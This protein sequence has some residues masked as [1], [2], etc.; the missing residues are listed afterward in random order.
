MGLRY[1]VSLAV[2]LFCVDVILAQTAAPGQSCEKN[3]GTSCEQC[4][5]NVSCLWCIK[6]QSC[7]TYP[8]KTILPPHAL[9]PLNDA[10][11]GLCSMNFQILI[12]TLSVVAAVIIIAFFVCLFCC[13][14]CEN[15]GSAAFEHHMQKK[16]E[17]RKIKQDSRKAE[18]KARHDEIRK[19]YGLSRASPY[20]R[21]ENPA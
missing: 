1:F 8:V 7:V 9:C 5:S 11:W 3:N 18:M 14:K 4:L 19:K 13:C 17:K 15:C 21:F 12:I 2:L 10:R 6:T 20:S 16:E